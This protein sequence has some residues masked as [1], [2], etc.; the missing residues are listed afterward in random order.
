MW[1]IWFVP[2]I[3]GRCPKLC[4]GN[5]ILRVTQIILKYELLENC[6]LLFK[7]IIGDCFCS[8]FSSEKLHFRLNRDNFQNYHRINICAVF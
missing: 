6:V 1:F 2:E 3:C 7:G 5:A 8:S 4:E